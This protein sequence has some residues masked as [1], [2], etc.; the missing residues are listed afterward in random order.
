[1]AIADA[2]GFAAKL[3]AQNGDKEDQQIQSLSDEL[4]AVEMRFSELDRIMEQLFEDKVAGTLSDARF[5]KLADRYEAEQSAVEKRIEELKSEVERL[6]VNRRDIS[7]W[8]ELIREYADIKELDRV[9]L[10]EL[11]EKITVGEAQVVDG[12]KNIEITIYYRFVGT[13]RL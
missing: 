2:D 13:V 10:G 7:A 1:M 5:R 12:V 4:G 11:V 3:A 6:C 8:L 9:V